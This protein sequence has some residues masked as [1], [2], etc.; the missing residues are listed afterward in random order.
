MQ[1]FV[2]VVM[3]SMSRECPSE[4]TRIAAEKNLGEV[5]GFVLY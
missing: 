4:I 3:E 5:I 2:A 1:S